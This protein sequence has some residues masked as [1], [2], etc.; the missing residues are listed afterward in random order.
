MP[1][2]KWDVKNCL[3][4][5][6]PNLMSK[7][8]SATIHKKR[9][10]IT[11]ITLN[12]ITDAYEVI[13]R[14]TTIYGAKYLPIFKRLHDEVSK[15]KSEQELLN[16]AKKI[17]EPKLSTVNIDPKTPINLSH[18]FSHVSHTNHLL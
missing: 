2:L 11:V 4:Q 12:D 18:I 10:P 13:A 9:P 16:K 5:C 7:T 17:A 1:T 8:N 6:S 14:I 15:L 3:K